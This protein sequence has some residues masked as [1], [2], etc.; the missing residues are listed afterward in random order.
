MRVST[1]RVAMVLL[2]AIATVVAVGAGASAFGPSRG[3]VVTYELDAQRTVDLSGANA[4]PG[5]TPSATKT[6]T[7]P[8]APQPTPTKAKSGC[9]QG[10]KQLAVEQYLA[11]IK[12]YGPVTVDGVQSDADCAAIKKFQ[13]RFGIRPVDGQPGR[14][15]A[16]VARRI[17]ASLT[18]AEQAKCHTGSGT[19]A[20]VDLTLQ[21]VWVVKNGVVVFGPTVV[22]T[23]KP[24]FAT[25]SGTFKI[26]GRALKSWSVPYKVWLPYWQQITGGDG[27]HQTTTYIHNT[28]IGSH[29]C[30]NLL[31]ADAKTLWTTIGHGTTV[32]LFGRRPGT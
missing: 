4:S 22:R 5:P 11:Q 21:T 28:A 15:T 17:A 2:G 18:P 26:G 20:C 10:D 14:T 25:P 19:T 1:S 9:K 16:D 8:K 12:T 31:P 27:F 6:A 29:G 23:G 3:E 30:V 13:T 32:K 7:T 24:G